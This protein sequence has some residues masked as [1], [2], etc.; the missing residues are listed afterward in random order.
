MTRQSGRSWS[1]NFFRSIG[2][3]GRNVKRLAFGALLLLASDTSD[4][5]YQ[6][7]AEEAQYKLRIHKQFLKE[8]IDKNFPVML[9]HIEWNQDVDEYLPK[10][11][12]AKV[13]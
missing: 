6:V 4:S 9:E 3:V 13:E 10:P 7:R 11:I 12:E 2:S 1:G 5:G 8:V